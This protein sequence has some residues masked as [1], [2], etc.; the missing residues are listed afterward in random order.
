MYDLTYLVGLAD[1]CAGD[2]IC[3]IG[4]PDPTDW[5]VER[6]PDSDTYTPEALAEKLYANIIAQAREDAARQALDAAAQA[7]KTAQYDPAPY[8]RGMQA[9]RLIDPAKFRSK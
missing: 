1:G 3:I 4:L 2:G 6:W 9:L 7:F 5:I 8:T